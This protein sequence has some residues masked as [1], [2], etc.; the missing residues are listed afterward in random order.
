MS[1]SAGLPR[2][3][4]RPTNGSRPTAGSPKVGTVVVSAVL[5]RPDLWWTALGVV[6]RFAA[7]GWW[8]RPPRRPLP[9][10]ELWRFRMTTAYG[11]PEAQPEPAD[12]IDYLE[13]CR[14]TGA[15]IR[16]RPQ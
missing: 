5:R 11:D 2:D 8:R 1:D 16:A 14:E 3:A 15:L 13:W 9:A 4:G 7:P 12:V 6:R 10:A